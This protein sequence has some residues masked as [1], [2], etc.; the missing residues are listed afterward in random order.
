MGIYYMAPLLG[1]AIGPI[2][3]GLL[4]NA[5]NWRG[6]FWFLAITAGSSLMA[7]LLFF[8]D[9]FRKERSAMYQNALKRQLADKSV[10]AKARAEKAAKSRV[11]T[12]MES[13]EQTKTEADLEKQVP[14]VNAVMAQELPEVKISF[15]ELIPFGPIR[16]VL[17]RINNVTI[18]F[19]SGMLS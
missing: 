11:G 7:F 8:K 10:R 19:A 2:F 9:T 5:F 14:A 16:I 1:P 12:P 4:T 6:P 18:L 3:G 17:R 13:R 15:R